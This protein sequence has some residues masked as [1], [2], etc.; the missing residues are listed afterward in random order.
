MK[1]MYDNNPNLRK[2]YLEDPRFA[3]FTKHNPQIID[4]N[5]K[6]HGYLMVGYKTIEQ[7]IIEKTVLNKKLA[8]GGW[9]ILAYIIVRLIYEFRTVLFGQAFVES[10][11]LDFVLTMAAGVSA[12]IGIIGVCKIVATLHGA[13]T[14]GDIERYKDAIDAKMQKRGSEEDLIRWRE[15]IS[16]PSPLISCKEQFTEDSV[17]KESKKDTTSDRMQEIDPT[18]KRIAGRVVIRKRLKRPFFVFLV[19]VALFVALFF[20]AVFYG[21]SFREFVKDGIGRTILSAIVYGMFGCVLFAVIG[22]I[23]SLIAPVT[24]N[25]IYR[26]RDDIEKKMAKEGIEWNYEKFFPQNDE[27]TEA[28]SSDC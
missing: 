3:D 25:D 21:S 10:K 14:L 28:G 20:I 6:S 2:D 17:Y 4:E 23:K 26:Y 16:T 15:R 24:K 22:L 9:M 8:K 12:V 7:L 27:D 5:G 11:A 13:I 1:T 19:A 18:E